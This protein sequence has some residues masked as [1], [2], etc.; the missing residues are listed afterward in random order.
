MLDPNKHFFNQVTGMRNSST[1]VIDKEEPVDLLETLNSD[2]IDES[3]LTI[4]A[5]EAQTPLLIPN[6]LSIFG[7]FKSNLD[8]L[9]RGFK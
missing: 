5:V 2:S 3:L 1:R 4:S 8:L 6:E 9:Q 7:L